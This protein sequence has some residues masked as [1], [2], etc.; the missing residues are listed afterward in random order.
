[1]IMAG[2]DLYDFVIAPLSVDS[3][4]TG[5]YNDQ[6]RFLVDDEVVS[7]F[8]VLT[9][10]ENFTTPSTPPR[11]PPGATPPP[12]RYPP[13]R[14]PAVSATRRAGR[15]LLLK[16]ALKLGL[17]VGAIAFA[18]APFGI[19]AF[20][21]PFENANEHNMLVDVFGLAVGLTCIVWILAGI[22]VLFGA[23][24]NLFSDWSD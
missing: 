14:P 3:I 2:D 7:L 15:S 5:P 20:M 11:R 6:V 16:L 9:V 4:A 1:M 13:I 22:P 21:V 17:L 8:L 12:R 10:R 19:M 18:G 23:I 24:G